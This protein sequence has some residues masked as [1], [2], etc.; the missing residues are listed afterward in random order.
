[1]YIFIILFVVLVEEE[2]ESLV[3]DSEEDDKL[4][5]FEQSLSP[6]DLALLKVSLKVFLRFQEMRMVQCT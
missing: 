5:Q 1:M 6:D 3:S 4:A 2:E